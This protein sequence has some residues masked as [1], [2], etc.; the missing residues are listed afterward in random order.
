MAEKNLYSYR[1]GVFHYDNLVASKWFGQTW[2]VSEKQASSNLAFQFKKNAGYAGF[3]LVRL[4][5]KPICGELKDG[6]ITK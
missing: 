4:A 5:G 2:A 1:G 3:C 6:E